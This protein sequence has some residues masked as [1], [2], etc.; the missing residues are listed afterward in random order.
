MYEKVVFSRK[1]M[2]LYVH[3]SLLLFSQIIRPWLFKG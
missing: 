2:I 1:K 3:V